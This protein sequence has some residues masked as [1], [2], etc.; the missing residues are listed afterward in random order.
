MPK[1]DKNTLNAYIDAQPSDQEEYI[2]VGM[3]TC[4]IAA[5][6]EAIFKT[7]IEETKMRHLS[8]AVR[9]CGCGGMCYAEPIVEVKVNGLPAVTYGKVSRDIAIRIVEKHVI[10]K[11]LLNECIFDSRYIELK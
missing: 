10:E 1:L 9:K 2:K 6:A 4:G 11:L 7:F 8:I 5:G 3:S